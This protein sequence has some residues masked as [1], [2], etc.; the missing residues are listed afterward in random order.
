MLLNTQKPSGGRCSTLL[1]AFSQYI[2]LSGLSALVSSFHDIFLTM[3]L[4]PFVQSL[5]NITFLPTRR[6]SS[7]TTYPDLITDLLAHIL[8]SEVKL[9]DVASLSRQISLALVGVIILTSIRLVLRGVTRVCFPSF[10]LSSSF[11][12]LTFYRLYVLQVAI[13]EP[14][15]CFWY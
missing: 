9:E 4:L 2:A 12:D 1:R 3:L 11:S 10:K 5:Y 6:S 14:R 13:S 15:S 8:S 7:T